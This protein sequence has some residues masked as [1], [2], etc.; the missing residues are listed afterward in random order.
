M[1]L[2][3]LL[4]IHFASKLKS[5]LNNKTLALM[6]IVIGTAMIIFGFAICFRDFQV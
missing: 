5:K 6:S 4:K 1:F 2:V 3:D